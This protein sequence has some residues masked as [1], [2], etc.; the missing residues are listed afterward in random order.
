MA[1]YENKKDGSGAGLR[2]LVES[3]LIPLENYNDFYSDLTYYVES[4][5]KGYYELEKQKQ[6][7]VASQAVLL[8]TFPNNL[9]NKLLKIKK[10]DYK[11]GLLSNKTKADFLLGEE[12]N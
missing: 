3:K 8:D 5:R 12:T 2:L 1:I 4:Q 6:A 7:I 11:Y 10:I 9:Y